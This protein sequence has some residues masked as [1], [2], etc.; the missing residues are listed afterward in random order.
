MLVKPDRTLILGGARSGKSRRA[1]ALANDKAGSAVFVATAEPVDEE[2]CERIRTHQKERN[3]GW[4]TIEVPLLLAETLRSVAEP[5]VV[6]IVDCLTVWLANLL[7]HQQEPQEALSRLV[8]WLA[9]PPPCPVIFVSNEVG[10]GLVPETPLGREFRDLQ[11][12]CNQTLAVH[13]DR[14]EF[15]AAGLPMTLKA[16]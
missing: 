4:K 8:S 15:V 3:P 16:P 14:V 7:H 11:G 13:C 1:T 10:L 12:H 6:L 5:E 2:F 9:E